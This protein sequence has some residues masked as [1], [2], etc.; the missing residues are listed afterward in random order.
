MRTSRTIFA[1]RRRQDGSVVLI[2]LALLAIMLIL[3]AANS[4]TLWHLHRELNLLEHRQIERLNPG[5][6][7]ATSRVKLPPGLDA[8]APR[9]IPG[10]AQ[11]QGTK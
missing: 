9:Q 11:S 6:T 3:T 8:Q 5:Q 2:L 1:P 10:G 7:N 4:T